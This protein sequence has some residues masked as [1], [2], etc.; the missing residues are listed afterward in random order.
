MT[1]ETKEQAQKRREEEFLMREVE[2]QHLRR[3]TDWAWYIKGARDM[4]LK[5]R[6][7]MLCDEPHPN[8]SF[9]PKAED[10]IYNKAI[11]DLIMSSKDNV[12]HFLLEE[13]EICYTDHERDKKGKLVKCRA[14]YARRVVKYEE[15]K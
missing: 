12:S 10:K 11:L 6:D 2:S 3:L 8:L 7:H 13:Y 5:L 1:R 14:Y 15:V 9:K 4:L